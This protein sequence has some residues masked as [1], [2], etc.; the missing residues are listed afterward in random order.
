MD[1][2]LRETSY[3]NEGVSPRRLRQ[4]L[5]TRDT[6]AFE[7]GFEYLLSNRVS[8]M[9]GVQAA[10]AMLRALPD[11]DPLLISTRTHRVAGSFGLGSYGSASELLMGARVA[12]EWGTV[13]AP[14][15]NGTELAVADRR[16]WETLLILSGAVSLTS[17]KR[18]AEHL[19]SLP[20]EFEGD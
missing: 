3:G 11:S 5:A 6:V 16:A 13:A 20:D 17:F 2:R 8:I 4:V 14:R 12:Y 15:F 1:A 18:A 7:T 10:P 19:G 9:G